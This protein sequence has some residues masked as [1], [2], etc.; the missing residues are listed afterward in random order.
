LVTRHSNLA[1][2]RNYRKTPKWRQVTLHSNMKEIIKRY[3]DFK[4]LVINKKRES[5]VLDAK[6][7]SS[8]YPRR[9]FQKEM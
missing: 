1:V 5:I 7:V 9:S 3:D 6:N 4:Q 8:T 2:I